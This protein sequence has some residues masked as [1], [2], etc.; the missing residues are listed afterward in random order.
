MVNNA[1]NIMSSGYAKSAKAKSL[2]SAFFRKKNTN[3]TFTRENCKKSTKANELQQ[4]EKVL[5]N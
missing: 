2:P 3:S 1:D 5:C 4:N